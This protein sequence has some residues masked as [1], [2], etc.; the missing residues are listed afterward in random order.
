MHFV[1]A[2]PSIKK[3]MVFGER[4]MISAELKGCVT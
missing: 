3:L 4:F 2:F 1:S